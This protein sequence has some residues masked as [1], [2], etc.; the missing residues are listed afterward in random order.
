M[1]DT[2]F[3]THNRRFHS[4][5]ALYE[6]LPGN[7]YLSLHHTGTEHI[8]SNA[9]FSALSHQPVG[10]V[11][12]RCFTIIPENCIIYSFAHFIGFYD[13]ISYY[14][15]IFQTKTEHVPFMKGSCSVIV[16]NECIYCLR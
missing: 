3:L 11:I 5:P 6:A 14:Y 8:F 2:A 12:M 16:V 15:N 10:I 9:L 1:N 13:I 7:L 4:L